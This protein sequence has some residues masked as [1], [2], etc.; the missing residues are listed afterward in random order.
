MMIA[1]VKRYPDDNDDVDDDDDDIGAIVGR[2]LQESAVD[3]VGDKGR[4]VHKILLIIA[5]WKL[6][7]STIPLSWL[8]HPS[9]YTRKKTVLQVN[10]L[11]CNSRLSLWA[12]KNILDN[13]TVAGFSRARARARA[14][15][16][17]RAE[18]SSRAL[19]PST[20]TSVEPSSS[21]AVQGSL[22][23]SLNVV[24]WSIFI[25]YL[26]TVSSSKIEL[27]RYKNTGTWLGVSAPSLGL[28]FNYFL[29]VVFLVSNRETHP[30]IN[31]K[32]SR[33]TKQFLYLHCKSGWL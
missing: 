33:I 28:P 29:T 6:L 5:L 12:S 30:S 16:S 17:T 14:E 7:W 10:S 3:D 21:R 32:R 20:S 22:K 27:Q 31:Q 9:S 11:S 1:Y 19:E 15:P 25:T 13:H 24:N 18:Y 4:E 26:W 8:Q 2:S 23:P